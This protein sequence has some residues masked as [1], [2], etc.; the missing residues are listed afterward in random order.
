M[1]VASL[2]TS[3]MS[4]LPHEARAS[5]ELRSHDVDVAIVGGGL[6][7]SLAAVVLGR[8]GYRVALIDRYEVFPAQF[9]VD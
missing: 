5:Q 4:Q 8:A 1:N 6:S 7:G 3:G 2:E 9:R